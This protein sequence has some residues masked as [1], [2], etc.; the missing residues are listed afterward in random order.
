MI[1]IDVWSAVFLGTMAKDSG[2]Y[3]GVMRGLQ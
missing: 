2:D 3:V 1:V